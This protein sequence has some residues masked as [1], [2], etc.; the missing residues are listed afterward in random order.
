L[1][2]SFGIFQPSKFAGDET[3]TPGFQGMAS[4]D[5][6]KD[7]TTGKLWVGGISQSTSCSTSAPCA[8]KSFTANGF[9]LGGKVG[10]GNFEA[11]AYAFTGSG[12]GLSTVGA[13]FYGGSNNAGNKTD[14]KGYFLQGTYKLGA[15]KFGINYGQNTDKNGFMLTGVSTLNEAKN[16]AYTLGVYHAL[17][18]YIT[19]VGELN[20]ERI[21]N[22]SDTNMDNKNRT[23]SFGG[24]IFF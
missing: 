16:K 13:Q 4:Y 2:A 14:S 1:Q 8:T 19:L 24:I 18:K 22:V 12:L 23:L 7:A 5:W 9:E 21:T 20:E 6:K 17:N 15:T 11:V 3:K 10:L